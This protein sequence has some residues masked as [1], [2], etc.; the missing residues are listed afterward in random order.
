MSI[1]ESIASA[2]GTVISILAYLNKA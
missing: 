1:A 2:G